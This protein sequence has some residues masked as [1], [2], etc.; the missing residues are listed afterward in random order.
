[1]ILISDVNYATGSRIDL[2]KLSKIAHENDIL[3]LVDGVQAIGNHEVNVKDLGVD[4]YSISRHK[5]LCGPDGAGALY[6]NKKAMQ[7]ILP[8]F[9]GIFSDAHHGSHEEF[10]PMTDA[11]RYEVST[12]PLPVIMG[13]TAATHWVRKNV[14]LKYILRRCRKLYNR[15]WDELNEVDK[16]TLFSQRDQNS[17]LSFSIKNRSSQNIM[18]KLRKNYIFTRTVNGFDSEPVRLSLG[19]WNRE[20]DIDQI[21]KV[22]KQC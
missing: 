1:M 19:F 13:G 4:G 11:Q 6:V 10:V 5:F 15:L 14:G 3:V 22:V 7:Q 12:R 9:T 18:E 17:L 2:K 20:S 16:I 21:L 8:T